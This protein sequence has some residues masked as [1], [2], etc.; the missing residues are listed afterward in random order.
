[1]SEELEPA[2]LAILRAL[3]DRFIP[4]V[5]GLSGAG[6]MGLAEVVVAMAKGHRRYEDAIGGVLQALAQV[7]GFSSLDGGRQ[8]SAIRNVEHARRRPFEL[9][10]E[11]VYIAYYSRPDVHARI[12][13]RTG[14][15]QPMGFELPAF[16]EAVISKA[17]ERAP[18]WRRT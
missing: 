6:S 18:F 16:D 11:L 12:G 17:R 13:W 3:L 9:L 8:D 7:E 1:M 2:E 10:I 15:L 4:P 14:P 5:D